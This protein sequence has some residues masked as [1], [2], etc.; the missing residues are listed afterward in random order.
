MKDNY[1]KSLLTIMRQKE[2]YRGYP[3]R[4]IGKNKYQ[5]G[6]KTGTKEEIKKFIDSFKK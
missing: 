3:L 4:Q 1:T 5:F 6:I 2:I